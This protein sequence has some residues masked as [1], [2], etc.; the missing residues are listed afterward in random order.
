MTDLPDLERPAQHPTPT[1]SSPTPARSTRRAG[2]YVPGEGGAI[3]IVEDAGKARERGA[4][5]TYG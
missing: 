3:L 1:P 2:G 5:N 4:R